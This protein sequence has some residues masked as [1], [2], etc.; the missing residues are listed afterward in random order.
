MNENGYSLSRGGWNNVRVY[1]AS[2]PS[3]GRRL[4]SPTVYADTE[5]R[6]GGIDY[7]AQ[8]TIG[9]YEVSAG[10][11]QSALSEWRVEDLRLLRAGGAPTDKARSYAWGLAVS[12]VASMLLPDTGILDWIE[13]EE[14]L[15]KYARLDRELTE[16][17]W[18][19]RS[20][21]QAAEGVR[22]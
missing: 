8:V 5:F 9:R 19:L 21:E 20:V 22:A 2:A 1:R 7:E 6:F 17:D 16:L 4:T 11:N 14:A 18:A 10:F 13:A 3:G 12:F 15:V